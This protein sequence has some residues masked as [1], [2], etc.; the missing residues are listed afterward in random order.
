MSVRRDQAK[1]AEHECATGTQHTEILFMSAAGSACA[2]PTRPA[3]SA[4][5][6]ANSRIVNVWRCVLRSERL[7]VKFSRYEEREKS[8]K[9]ENRRYE[10]HEIQGA[11]SR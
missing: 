2:L 7:L 5:G 4:A 3:S 9:E 11:D 10:G 6:R 8:V 1:N